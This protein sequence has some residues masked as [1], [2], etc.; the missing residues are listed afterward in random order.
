[1]SLT[2]RAKIPKLRTIRISRS[3]ETTFETFVD[4]LE[5]SQ[6]DA[7]RVFSTAVSPLQ[8]SIT[9]STLQQSGPFE[10]E[11]I[12]AQVILSQAKGSEGLLRLIC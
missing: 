10:L 4:L 8:D 7:L 2:L 6:G 3:N 5:V 1:M 12:D 9:Y 11:K